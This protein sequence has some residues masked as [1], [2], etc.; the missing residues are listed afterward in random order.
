MISRSSRISSTIVLAV[1]VASFVCLLPHPADGGGTPATGTT[2]DQL[3]NQQGSGVPTEYGD[4]IASSSAI[5]SAYSYWLEVPSGLSRLVVEIFDADVYAGGAADLAGERDRQ[6]TSGGS[7]EYRLFDPSG[8]EITSTNFTDGN[9][10]SPTGADN[11]WLVF[12]DTQ[13]VA[14]FA[15]VTTAANTAGTPP[16]YESLSTATNPNNVTSLTI[17]QPSGTTSGDLLLA[18]IS[19][20]GN[21]T[22]TVTGWTSINQGQSPGGA[23]TLSL[24]YRVRVNLRVTPLAGR[25]G[26]RPPAAFCATATSTRRPRSMFPGLLPATVTRPPRR[27]PQR[28]PPTL[29]WYGHMAPMTTTC[30]GRP[31]RPTRRVASAFEAGQVFLAQQVPAQ[32]TRCRPRSAPREPRPSACQLPSSGERRR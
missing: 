27:A 28:L 18:I 4:Y 17:N 29:W 15:D 14:S 6:L 26:R 7:V 10:T 20:D 21:V 19:T 5:D 3:I 22:H 1:V 32:P 8:T 23:S 30:L 9:A 31:T 25:E 16:T 12:Y 2:S 11:A 13:A 24:W